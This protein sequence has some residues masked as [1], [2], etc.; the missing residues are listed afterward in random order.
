LCSTVDAAVTDQALAAGGSWRCRICGQNWTA[1]RLAT[2]AAY[3]AWVAA[4]EKR[5]DPN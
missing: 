3:A 4:R 5:Y 2:A 1:A